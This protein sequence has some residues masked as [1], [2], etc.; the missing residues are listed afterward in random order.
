[1][2]IWLFEM[3]IEMTKIRLVIAKVKFEY[4]LRT[5]TPWSSWFIYLALTT[6]LFYDFTPV[7]ST[8]F[9]C[10]FVEH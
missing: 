9:S 3:I 4:V 1:M 8:L 2:N 10:Q 7:R 6:M 5:K